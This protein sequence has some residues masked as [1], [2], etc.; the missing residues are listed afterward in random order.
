MAET[1]TQKTDTPRKL[2]NP[3]GYHGHKAQFEWGETTA[4]CSPLTR[5]PLFPGIRQ[6]LRETSFA[7]DTHH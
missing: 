2:R 6:N 1:W 5:V 3:S 7:Y 4:S